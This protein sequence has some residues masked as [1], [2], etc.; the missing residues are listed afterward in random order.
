M[1]PEVSGTVLSPRVYI[2]TLSPVMG[3]WTCQGP[4][5]VVTGPFGPSTRITK[6]QAFQ[7]YIIAGAFYQPN[8]V[9]RWPCPITCRCERKVTAALQHGVTQWSRVLLLGPP[10]TLT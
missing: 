3:Q 1:T 4:N 10:G 9:L 8:L 7:G 6:Y 2:L 5:L